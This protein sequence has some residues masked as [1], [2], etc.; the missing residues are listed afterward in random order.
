MFYGFMYS[1]LSSI[2]ICTFSLTEANVG[3][4]GKVKKPGKI[5]VK[6]FQLVHNL[7]KKFKDA[8]LPLKH[9]STNS[10]LKC[11]GETAAVEEY[12]GIA[13]GLLS[14]IPLVHLTY[15]YGIPCKDQDQPVG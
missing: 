5:A 12:E 8:V 7:N 3:G 4:T 9:N 10:V 14:D 6:T 11:M 2:S 1:C 15:F 13:C